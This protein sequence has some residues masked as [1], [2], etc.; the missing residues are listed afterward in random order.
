[1]ETREVC[2]ICGRELPNRWAV[3]GRC[4]A[5]GCGAAFCALHWHVGSR[6]CREHGWNRKDMGKMNEKKSCEMSEESEIRERAK[7]EM[8]PQARESVL[9]KVAAFAV[10]FGKGATSL[11]DR[12]RGVKDPDEAISALD[13]QLAANRERREPLSARAGKLY[14]EIAAKKKV[15]LSAPPARKKMMELELRGLISEYQGIER[16]LVV[17]FE[18]ERIINTVRG[19]TLELT[20]MGLRKISE[21][22]IDRLTDEIDGAAGDAEDVSD[23]MRDLEKAGRRR[24]TDDADAFADALAGFDENAADAETVPS[25]EAGASDPFADFGE[26]AVNERR[27]EEGEM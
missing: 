16:Q 9:K 21:K 8:S 14:L 15:Y 23:A 1:M 24:D 18:N 7:T 13:A 17:Y 26:P 4:E 5:D 22:D 10:S 6:L 12:I 3:A 19:R 20:A 25:A 2:C 27:S 11:V